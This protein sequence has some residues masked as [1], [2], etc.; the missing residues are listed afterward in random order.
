MERVE[1]VVET[2]PEPIRERTVEV[3]GSRRAPNV[4]ERTVM[5]DVGV[6]GRQTARVEATRPVV[7]TRDPEDVIITPAAR[8][9]RTVVRP[10]VVTEHPQRVYDAKRTIF[11]AYQIIWYILA[12]IEILLAFRFVFH[13]MGANPY[14]GF[15]ALIY[16]LSG[17]LVAPFVGIL[18]A[19][20]AGVSVFEWST[21]IAAVV[22]LLIAWG[23]VYLFQ[24]IKPVD[25]VEV[26][27][28]VD[29]P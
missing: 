27:E 20:G 28:T 15:V 18:P 2:D 1:E 3:T 22:Y 4:V 19:Y 5:D 13:L 21:I 29:N 17:I 23:L 7:V 11:R 24:L 8:R 9:T 25:P 10:T 6:L 14:S 12:F 16:G 26:E